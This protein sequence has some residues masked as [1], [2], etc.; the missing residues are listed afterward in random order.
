[1]TNVSIDSAVASDT[2]AYA[3]FT[4]RVQG[5]MIDYIV[6]SLLIAG[7]LMIAVAFESNSIGRILGFTVA[8]IWL[9]YEPVLVSLTGS[10]LGHR[11]CNIRVV[12]NRGGNIG[13]AKAVLRTILKTAFGWLSFLTMAFT[14]RHQAIHDVLTGS[15]VQIRDLSKARP[16][17]FRVARQGG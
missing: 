8:A 6:I 16:F 3:R 1:M 17:D 13:F 11:Y 12:D 10:T 15:T 4:R 9:L 2:P 5:M 7:A 14:S